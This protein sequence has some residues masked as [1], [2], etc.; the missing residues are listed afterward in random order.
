MKLPLRW[1]LNRS[2]GIADVFLMTPVFAQM[3]TII[4]APRDC[5]CALDL[6]EI[7]RSVATIEIVKDPISPEEAVRLYSPSSIPTSSGTI[8]HAAKGHLRRYG[9][10]ETDCIPRASAPNHDLEWATIFLKAYHN[11]VTFAPMPGGFK[12]PMDRTARGKFLP[13]ENWNRILAE[14]GKNHDILYFTSRDNY[15]PMPHCHPIIGLSPSKMAAIMQLTRKHVGV[16][17]GLLHM[18]IAMGCTVH[19]YIPSIGIYENHC[20]PIYMYT[21]DMF[22]TEACRAFYHTFKSIGFDPRLTNHQVELPPF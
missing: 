13:P 7:L 9:L 16:E 22:G 6:A 17:N 12:N 15:V 10:P 18:A 2:F 21:Q 11:P 4:E 19:A 3:D 20:F 5:V 14:N 8:L 1:G